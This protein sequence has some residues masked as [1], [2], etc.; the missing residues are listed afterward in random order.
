MS[1]K[2]N[3]REISPQEKKCINANAHV[4]TYYNRE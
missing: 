4:D 2:Y 1:Y 3:I